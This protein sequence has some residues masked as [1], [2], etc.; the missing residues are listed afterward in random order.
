MSDFWRRELNAS[1]LEAVEYCDGPSLVIAGAGSGKTRVLTYKIAY[2]IQEKHISPYEI[3]ALTFTNKAAKEMNERIAK[4]V[5]NEEIQHLWSGTFHS[6]FARI[7]RREC[8][9]IDFQQNFTIYDSA[10]SKS[11]LK[12][13]I[14]EMAL[15]DKLYKPGIVQGRISDAKNRLVFP[16]DYA[17]DKD[18]ERRDSA[19]GIP[20]LPRIYSTYAQRCRQ[21]NAMDFDDLLLYTYQLFRDNPDVRERYKN[22][23]RYILVDEYQDTNYAQHQII[24]QLTEPGSSICVVGDDAQSIYAFRGANIDNILNFTRQFPTA[25]TVKLERNYRSTQN[26]VNAANSIIGHNARQIPKTVYSENALGSPIR[27]MPTNS[28]REEAAKIVGE[29]RRLARYEHLSYNDMAILYRVNALSRSFEDEM[30]KQGIPYRIYGGLSFYQRKEIKDIISYFR[31]LCNEHD[32]EAFRRVVNY[33]ARGIGKTTLENLQGCA[34]AHGASLWQVATS[35]ETYG[36]KASRGLTAIREFCALILRLREFMESHSAYDVAV[37]VLTL[38]NM[39]ADLYSSREA[40]YLSKQENIEELLSSIKSLEEDSLEQTGNSFVSISDYLSQVS[41]LTDTEGNTDSEERVTLMTIHAAKGLEYNTVFLVGVEEDVFPGS[42]A[43]YPRQMEEERRLF[44]VAV[45]R[46][47]ER[48]FMSFARSR[49]RYGSVEYSEPSRFIRE[50][51][52]R[53]VELDNGNRRTTPTPSQN[54]ILRHTPIAPPHPR[55]LSQ[56]QTSHVSTTATSSGSYSAGQRV[57]HERFGQG[58]ILSIEGAGTNLCAIV[59]FDA[60]G[61]KKLLLKFARLSLI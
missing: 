60:V 33:P 34:R 41:L 10:D 44:Y 50:I 52:A 27:I 38:S 39:R 29:I 42:Q 59:E 11:L 5:G 24:C 19:D 55:P 31:L 12:T 22:R 47:K 32:E 56:V 14:K 3:M 30:R 15:D 17:N 7:L 20:A 36:F 37:Q 51:D 61:T 18:A 45:T 1:Q 43:M 13:I 26:I 8:E 9:R 4:I 35:P 21:A 46:A 40:E 57:E 58:T 49:F 2:L 16:E 28:D 48:C 53:Y 54:S 23:Y 6:I 25:I